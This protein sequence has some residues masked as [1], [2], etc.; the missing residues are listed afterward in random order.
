MFFINVFEDNRLKNIYNSKNI[1]DTK[2]NFFVE[3]VQKLINRQVCS[4]ACKGTKI[5]EKN[6]CDLYID[7]GKNDYIF[8]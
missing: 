4:I 5:A 7:T 1:Q 3:N 2:K 6:I 8:C